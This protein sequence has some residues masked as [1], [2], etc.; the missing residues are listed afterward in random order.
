MKSYRIY[1]HFNGEAK[2]AIEL[3]SKVF[4]VA[5]PW[6]MTYGET[7]NEDNDG[8]TPTPADWIAHAALDGNGIRLLVDDNEIDYPVQLGD[9]IQIY[10]EMD[11]EEELRRIFK[12]IS[13]GGEVLNPIAP[14]FWGSL[15]GL[16]KDRFG[17]IW[18]CD[19]IL[20]SS[21]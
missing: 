4:Q 9:A 11:T 6:I 7:P 5:E 15:F 20:P 16:T 14:T 2:Q 13:D 1:L 18:Q 12:E 19:Y 3:Y 10:L 8:G 21:N 17:V